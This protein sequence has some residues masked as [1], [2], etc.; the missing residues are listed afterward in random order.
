[1]NCLVIKYAGKSE[2]F[3]FFYFM[4]PIQ[5]F[6][7]SSNM[8]FFYKSARENNFVSHKVKQ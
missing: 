3:F 4:G 2:N 1:M 7:G 6:M 5:V 8:Y